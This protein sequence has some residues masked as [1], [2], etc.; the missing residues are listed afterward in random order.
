MELLWPLSHGGGW[1]DVDVKVPTKPHSP[2]RLVDKQIQCHDS[3]AW[4]KNNV[5]KRLSVFELT[6]HESF[7]SHGTCEWFAFPSSN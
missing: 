2:Q 5:E 3:N 7:P 6:D 1:K 4:W